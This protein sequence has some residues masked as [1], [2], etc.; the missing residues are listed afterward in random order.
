MTAKFCRNV[1]PFTS[2]PSPVSENA[3]TLICTLVTPEGMSEQR[4]L[5]FSTLFLPRSR[6]KLVGSFME[7][8]S[9]SHESMLS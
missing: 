1:D 9:R 2:T 4:T 3:V 6:V 7:K 8:P 5:T